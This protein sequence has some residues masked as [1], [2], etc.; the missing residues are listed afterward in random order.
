MWPTGF[1][2]TA[3]AKTLHNTR[4]KATTARTAGRAEPM[5]AKEGSRRIKA[6]SA[7][8]NRKPTPPFEKIKTGLEYRGGVVPQDLSKL[9]AGGV[10]LD[11]EFEHATKTLESIGLSGYEARG[12]IALVAHGYGSAETIAETAKIPRTSAYKV[13]QSLCQKGFAISTRGRPT[14]FK[15]EAPSKVKGRVIDHLE[16]TFAKLDMLHEVL[17]AKGEPQLVYT[18]VSKPRVLEKIGELIDQSS[19]TCIVSTPTFS[20]IRE[21]VG[22]KIGEPIQCGGLVTP[23]V[24]EYVDCKETIIGSVH[25]A[26][27]YSPSGRRL[28]IDGHRTQAVVVQRAMFDRAIATDAVRKGAHTFLGAQAQ[29]ARRENGGVEISI[30]QDG[31]PRKLH[32][33][34]LVGCDGV[35]SNVAK[36]FNIL[37][38]RKILPGFEVEMTG[39]Q[40]D[41]G[42]VTLFIGNEIAPGFF[43]WI[44]PSG[45][46]ARVGLCVGEGNAYAYLEKMLT[47]PE[48]RKYTKGAQPILYIAGGIP[49]GF[50]RRTYADNVL[51]VGDAACQA[52]AVSGGGIFT[53]LTCSSFAAQTAIEALEADDF[54]GR[55]LHRYHRAWTKSIGKELRKDLAIHESFSRLMDAQFEE[56]F[57]IFDSPEMLHLIE[58]KGDIDFPSKVGW[59]LIKEDPRL[60][61]YVGKALRAMIARNVGV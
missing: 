18:I 59:A 54:S 35:R 4:R 34:L 20:E 31:E 8:R 56:L 22:K 28:V 19:E 30:D 53:A 39:V 29:A 25:G 48:V 57:D 2:P 36:W 27:L 14:I 60:L 61:K 45:D 47:R 44:I 40:G 1:W 5:T 23:R 41:P 9:L 49:L 50:P 17:R 52:K 26:E 51:V 32:A 42:F 6:C 33:K 37:R 3:G 15:P 46:T 43:G 58:K 12:Y 7:F 38:P 24:F 21:N 13:L 16:D 11:Q 55:M 10:D